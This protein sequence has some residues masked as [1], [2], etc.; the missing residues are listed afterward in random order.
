MRE[1]LSLRERHVDRRV[2]VEDPARKE[3]DHAI[4]RRH[5][6]EVENEGMLLPDSLIERLGPRSHVDLIA[7][8][9]PGGHVFGAAR[10]VG[11]R[12]AQGP[13][14]R[15]GE[16]S[17]FRDARNRAFVRH[18]SRAFGMIDG[19][20]RGLVEERDLPQFFRVVDLK[21]A[22]GVR[23]K[24]RS[25][26][27]Q[28]LARIP[29][30]EVDAVIEEPD[31][32]APER[33]GNEAPDTRLP[34]PRVDERARSLELLDFLDDRL[35]LLVEEVLRHAVRP[36]GPDHVGLRAC[37]QAEVRR[38]QSREARHVEVPRL[39]LDEASD[40]LLVHLSRARGQPLEN[41]DQPAV[42]VS[43]IIEEDARLPA[44]RHQEIEVA[45]LVDVVSEEG[46]YVRRRERERRRGFLR[47]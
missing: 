14:T 22:G 31:R 7:A 38:Q 20:Q 5:V 33:V 10:G 34:V 32:R 46:I 1:V 8:G 21:T 47:R 15:D 12:G 36:R 4:P 40:S 37:A 27:E 26:D 23:P 2:G 9:E 3:E 16:E 44:G 24:R 39:D 41:D 6:A 11:E 45:V 43:A 13:R 42:R 18:D 35:R 17:L 19:H 30:R 28:P 25:V 29:A